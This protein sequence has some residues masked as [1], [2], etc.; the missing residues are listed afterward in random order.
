[1]KLKE[2]CSS[3][4]SLGVEI[5]SSNF[6]AVE[7]P[8][9][10]VPTHLHDYVVSDPHSTARIS[11]QGTCDSQGKIDNCYELYLKKV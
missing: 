3:L 6:P 2:S 4:K 5:S 8:G 11:K 1:M 10:Y 9:V 7:E